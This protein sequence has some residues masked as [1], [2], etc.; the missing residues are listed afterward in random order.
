MV[1]S[2]KNI[3]IIYLYSFIGI[4]LIYKYNEVVNTVISTSNIGFDYLVLV[5]SYFLSFGLFLALIIIKKCDLLEPFIFCSIILLLIYIITPIINILTNDLLVFGADVM[6]GS[7]KGTIIFDLSYIGFSIGYFTQKNKGTYLNSKE[8]FSPSL[9]FRYRNKIVF[10]TLIFWS[11]CFG[12]SL[13][14]IISTG[15]S[16]SYILS[17]GARGVVSNNELTGTSLGFIGMF[18]YSMVTAWMLI[19]VYSKNNILKIVI[20]ILTLI[21][22]I[23]RGYRFIIIIMIIAPFSY[24]YIKKGKRPST[25]K[26]IILGLIL[27]IIVGI[28]GF[29]RLGLRSGSEISW[30][31]FG[32]DTIINAIKGN[33]NI[34][35]TYYGT[36]NAVP[37]IINYTYGKQMLYTFIMFIPRFFWPNKPYP[38]QSTIV[39]YSINSTAAA[40]GFAFPNLG[41]YYTEFGIMGCIIIMVLFGKVAAKCKYLYKSINRNENTIIS[42]SIMLP[43]FMQVIIRGYTPSNFYLIVFLFLPIWIINL[44]VRSDNFEE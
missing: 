43:A 4:F 36:I 22:Y 27:S 21:T 5:F 38:L 3:F 8:R 20:G 30:N 19:L 31:I 41:E 12:F 33:F 2:K 14:Y 17:L 40:S 11:V 39:E 16:I 37:D 25:I 15:A 44:F 13:L 34:Y 23:I 35:K 9:L 18:G 1:F 7:V 10:I 29:A 42:Y 26:L 6:R 28:L 24:Y 32:I